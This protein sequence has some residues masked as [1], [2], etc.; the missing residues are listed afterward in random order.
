MIRAFLALGL[1]DAISD[2][3]VALQADLPHDMAGAPVP[4][5]NFH[6]TLSFLGTQPV[7]VLEDLHLAL[8]PLRVP[9]FALSLSGVDLFGSA[10]PRAAIAKVAPSQALAD[11]HKK[12]SVAARLTGIELERRRFVPHVTLAR[13][14]NP[15]AVEAAEMRDFAARHADF[16]SAEFQAKEVSLYRSTLRRGGPPT[17]EVIAAYPLR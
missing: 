14:R 4:E 7:P 5:E 2:S 15:N 9:A 17:Y 1:P 11:L 6:I 16:R 10:R 8:E 3:L 12:V 13:L